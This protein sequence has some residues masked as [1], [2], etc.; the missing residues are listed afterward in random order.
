LREQAEQEEKMRDKEMLE[1]ALAKERALQEL[2][3]KERQDRRNEVVELRKY[4]QQQVSD[5][6]AY[7]KMIE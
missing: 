2:E 6:D 3:D 7:E 1:Q 4:Y 5:R